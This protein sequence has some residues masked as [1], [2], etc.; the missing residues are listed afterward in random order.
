MQLRPRRELTTDYSV[1]DISRAEIGDLLVIRQVNC[2]K[3]MW[4]CRCE[5]GRRQTFPGPPLRDRRVRGCDQCYPSSRV[6]RPPAAAPPKRGRPRRAHAPATVSAPAPPA[7]RQKP[8]ATPHRIA[9]LLTPTEHALLE[10]LHHYRLNHETPRPE[11]IGDTAA[12]AIACCADWPDDGGWR[13][14]NTR[15]MRRYR[16]DWELEAQ[17]VP[18]AVELTERAAAALRRL[19]AE[20]DWLLED[21]ARFAIRNLYDAYD[22]QVGLD[23]APAEDAVTE[24]AE[25]APE[26]AVQP[27]SEPQEEDPSPPATAPASAIP[28]EE[29]LQQVAPPNP[30][31]PP[32]VLRVHAPPPREES[33][34]RKQRAEERERRPR[35]LP[36]EEPARPRVTYKDISSEQE[37]ELIRRYQG[38]DRRAGDI[39]LQAHEPL[40]YQTVRPFFGMGLDVEDVLQAGRMGLLRGIEKFEASHGVRLTTY[41]NWW[42]RQVARLE[43][44]ETGATIRLPGHVHDKL[45]AAWKSGEPLSDELAEVKRLQKTGSLDAPVGD[46]GDGTLGML[47]PDDGAS[48]EDAVADEDAQARRRELISRAMTWLNPKER[49][50][51][52]R[53]L[54]VDEPETL[55]EVGEVFE[56]SRE[57]IR[58]IEAEGMRKL[59][60]ALRKLAAGD[61]A[62]L[63]GGRVP[64]RP[65][66]RSLPALPAPPPPP[67]PAVEPSPASMV[68]PSAPVA[69]AAPEPPR[70][71]PIPPLP[72][73]PRSTPEQIAAVRPL[74]P[75][76]RKPAD[77]AWP[78]WERV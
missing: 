56:V 25:A 30:V 24:A 58:Q 47:V 1:R 65:A 17:T 21:A 49:E 7:A 34:T 8:R 46:D 73:Q 78:L 57:R 31:P 70:A 45:Y 77:D 20:M 51:V 2:R 18:L 48:P 53:R 55:E 64:D 40:I 52:R 28:E 54:L 29:P 14:D 59:E 68:V 4:L 72:P 41:A 3:D 71:K 35:A 50:V 6:R 32:Q 44:R 75:P 39:L 66:R 16:E 11:G 60:K 42:V 36:P 67:A 69:P 74:R 37:L 76:S 13:A 27:D 33:P 12:S 9:I 23:E 22:D 19:A 26:Q 63:W 15:T 61:D 10:R 38:G 62:V 5:C 43:V